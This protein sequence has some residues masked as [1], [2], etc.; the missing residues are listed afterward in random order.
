V[1]RVVIADDHSL[2]RGGFRVMLETEDDIR[3]VGEAADGR[4]AID[5]VRRARPDVVVMDIRMPLLDGIEATRQITQADLPT[6]VLVVTTFDLDEYVFAALR[7]GAAG[8]LLKEATPAQL[9]E[10]VRTVADGEALLAP[11]VTRRLVE[12]FVQV[13]EPDRAVLGALAELTERER[14]VL[15]L[16]ARGLSNQA[17]GRELFLSEAT[18]KTHVTRVLA[19]LGLR[20]RTQAV[21]LAY[22]SGLVRVGS[23]HDAGA[24]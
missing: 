21:V 8:F 14:D 9:V 3:V 5:A 11:R 1:I 20:S 6:R 10:A 16:I 2:V 12:H 13:P 7:A 18:I 19:K 22:E 23:Q 15:G 24:A 4:D 17:I